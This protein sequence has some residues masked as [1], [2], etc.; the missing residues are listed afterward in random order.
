MKI[1]RLKNLNKVKTIYGYDQTQVITGLLFSIIGIL[2]FGYIGAI[3]LGSIGFTI[4]S[5]MSPFIESG[6]VSVYIYWYLPLD[7]IF[8]KIPKSEERFWR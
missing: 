4:G 1:K 2:L 7:F 5:I 6:L 8:R 3:I